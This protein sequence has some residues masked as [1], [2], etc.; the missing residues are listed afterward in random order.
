V[1]EISLSEAQKFILKKQGILTQ[2]PAQSILEVAKRIHNIQI[3]TISVV[4]RSHDLTVFTRFPEYEEKS[5][6][7]LQKHKQLFESVSHALCLLPI[8]AYPFYNWLMKIYRQSPKSPYWS[9][10]IQS[11]QHVIDQV[12]NAIQQQGAL[13]S[14]DFKVP[15]ERRSKGWWAWKSEKRA[16]EYLFHTGQLLIQYRKGFQK[17]YDLPE[18][19]L[20]PSIDHEPM[21]IDE[22][23]E[24]LCD[25][26]FAS[27]GIGNH[28]EMRCYLNSRA[29]RYLWNNKPDRITSFL[30]EQVKE[31]KLIHVKITAIKE[32]HYIRTHDIDLLLN[33]D[34]ILTKQMHL[35]NPF[36]NIIRERA[37][38]TKYWKFNYTLEA[39]TPPT[40]RKYGYYLMP[41]LDGHQ[42]IGM[43]EPKVHRKE[44]ILEIKSLFFEPE[45]RSTHQ[46]LERL[47]NCI[48]AFAKFHKCDQTRI[49][50]V[51]PARFQTQIETVLC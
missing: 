38:L 5:I 13:S 19:V 44:G 25:Q 1:I 41:I 33:D 6:W 8:N 37:L 7:E 40:Q 4:A 48:H 11:N 2:N 31:N 47:Y 22:I 46:S 9:K 14:K 29:T 43:L 45:Y 10:W 16:L 12:Y 21:P 30:D 27:F 51:S 23:P 20:L 35:I 28:Q 34:P 24:Y 36:D 15:P 50:T 32:P 42:F 49:G 3:D 39:Y 18:R 17:F 26:T